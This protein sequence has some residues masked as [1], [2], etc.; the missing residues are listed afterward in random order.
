MLTVKCPKC[1]TALKLQQA[2]ASGQVKCPKC[3]AVV[4]V[5][6]TAPAG[7]VVDPN[8]DTF[9]FGQVK[10][11][12][13]VAAPTV[14][15]F[16]SSGNLKPYTGPI[17]GD[18]LAAVAAPQTSGD[19]HGGG[20]VAT[21]P[22]K[23]KGISPKMLIGILGGVA[24][25]LVGGIVAVVMMSGSGG[26]EGPQVDV[27]A[28]AQ[29]AAPENYSAVG[30]YGTVVLVPKGDDLG[31]VPSAIESRAILS[32][33]SG[34]VYYL[35]AMNGGKL[36]IDNEQMRKKASRMLGGDVLGGQDTER[37]GYKGIKGMLDGS[38]FLPRMQV[39]I[40]HVNEIFAIIGC[41]PASMGA[42]PS[43]PVDRA[44]ETEEQDIFYKS[45]KIGSPPGGW[46]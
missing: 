33:G 40:Y 20:A 41:A 14:S 18:P 30:I 19:P 28:E 27:I 2:P 11:P 21:T 13:A 25:L 6:A 39:E 29:A 17:P 15:H 42:D 32:S 35:G 31:E 45:F 16:R 4:G 36:E 22:S 24:L 12:A 26:S 5:R 23:K 44:L 46:F 37:N 1:S 10:F 43:V 34:S 38:V 9:D 8:D 3:G 7:R